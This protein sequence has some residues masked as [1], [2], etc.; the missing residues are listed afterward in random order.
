MS[1][2]LPQPL[3]VSHPRQLTRQWAQ[4][5]LQQ[6]DPNIQVK[7][8]KL[9]SVDVGTTTRIRLHVDHTGP[10][11]LANKWFIKIPSL[12]WRAKVIT[13]LPR[14]L[15]TETRFYTELA[16]HS[17]INKPTA[18]S[19]GSRFGQGSTLV[20]NDITE[21]GAR[22]GQAHEHLSPHQ[23]RLMIEQLAA[24][25]ARFWN[26]PG[27]QSG[28]NWL[29]GPV[30]KLEDLLGT[31]LA[32]PLMKRGLKLAAEL[33]PKHLH[34][35]ALQ[36]ARNRRQAMRFLT[37]GKQ[38]I[39]HHDCHPGNLFWH[40][41]K[42]GLLDWQMV[43]SG[44]GI[45]DIAYLL[46]TALQPKTRQAEE[47]SLIKHYNNCL[48]KHGIYDFNDPFIYQRY[49][50]HLC[51]PLE[52]MLVTLAVGGMMELS[53]NKTLIQRCAIAVEQNNSFKALIR[54]KAFFK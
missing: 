30:R 47:K 33:V 8:V 52:A 18:L 20:L 21:Y 51:Y 12:S 44:E 25:H 16:Q 37:Q 14:L 46:A 26:K 45:S 40:D 53:A 2:F 19:A 4:H 50:A 48:R 54:N 17:P 38:T 32:V 10:A 28:L 15:H 5:L 41:K 34:H 3:I 27:H 31:A 24:L 13:A 43:R 29:A 11:S 23:A 39:V 35:P 49:Q 22:P 36:Y 9:T 42:P 6:H 7:K 1:F